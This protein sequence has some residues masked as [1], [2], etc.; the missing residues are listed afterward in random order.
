MD[1]FDRS[2]PAT[3]ESAAVFRQDFSRWVDTLGASDQRRGDIV[4]S[5]YEAVANAAEHAYLGDPRPGTV[6]VHAHLDAA[7][8]LEVC[9]VDT[10]SWKPVT[11]SRFRGR[12][13]PL[14]TALSDT[15]TVTTGPSGTTVRLHWRA[16]GEHYPP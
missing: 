13:L 2:L 7:G 15:S 8:T 6:R 4:L 9:V 12:G 16:A 10:G 5:V 3:A 11:P 1:G 14:M